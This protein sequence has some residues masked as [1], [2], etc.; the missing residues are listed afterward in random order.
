[1]RVEQSRLQNKLI[2]EA[3]KMRDGIDD[4]DLMTEDLL[5]K[6]SR[7]TANSILPDDSRSREALD[8]IRKTLEVINESSPTNI[9]ECVD[10]VTKRLETWEK[11]E[12]L[13]KDLREKS[14]KEINRLRAEVQDKLND[15]ATAK[16]TNEGQKTQY[17]AQIILLQSTADLNA[18]LVGK[19]TQEAADKE[20]AI[21]NLKNSLAELKNLSDEQKEELEKLQDEVNSNSKE[22][23]NLRRINKEKESQ[24]RDLTSELETFERTNEKSSLGDKEKSEILE[25]LKGENKVLRDEISEKSKIIDEISDNLASQ[26]RTSKKLDMEK[27]AVEEELE[28]LKNE[29]HQLKADLMRTST[30]KSELE[31][32]IKLNEGNSPE[33]VRHLEKILEEKQKE[34][35]ESEANLVVAKRY[36]QLYPDLVVEKQEIDNKLRETIIDLEQA[37]RKVEDLKNESDK[38]KFKLSN[39]ENISKETADIQKEN[40]KLKMRLN[41][42]EQSSGVNKETVD[43]AKKQ[44]ED[45]ASRDAQIK[46]LLDE[47]ERL[48][49][50]LNNQISKYNVALSRSFLVRLCH[51]FKE[52]EGESF[53]KWRIFR[54]EAKP[55]LDFVIPKPAIAIESSA[56]EKPFEKGYVA[57]DLV[58]DQEGNALLDSNPILE[59]Y[60]SLNHANEKPMSYINIFKFLEELMDKKFEADNQDALNLRPL[61]DMPSFVMETLMNTFGIQS[62]ANKFLSQFIPGFHQIVKDGHVYGNFFARVIQLFHPDPAPLSLAA[63]LV[64]ARVDF[65]PLIEK[66]DRL[67][68]DLSKDGKKKQESTG[69]AAYENAG[70]GGLALVGDAI[71][72][73]YSLFK[74]DRESGEKA[75]ELIRP[76]KVSIEDFVAF[77]ICHKMAKLGKTPEMIFTLLDK[78][79]GGTI[80]VDEFISG[81]KE[82]LDLW[83]SD[84]NVTKLLKL[85]DTN[86]NNEITKEAFMGK[87]NMKFLIECN[88][89]PTWVVSKAHYLVALLEVFKFKQRKLM[90]HLHEKCEQ[91]G[92]NFGKEDFI[93]LISEY[94]PNLNPENAE[95]LFL[96]ARN[97]QTKA[98][99]FDGISRIMSRYG[100]G[101]LKSFKIR[102]FTHELT[103]REL[104]AYLEDESIS[105]SVKR[106]STSFVV[107]NTRIER[108]EEE[109]VVIKKKV[110]KKLVKRS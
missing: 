92:N 74:S 75:L 27:K 23:R 85:L 33:E 1:M 15:L 103:R 77:K 38:N 84:A 59:A 88:K 94:D 55:V 5:G 72:L 89:N 20:A 102:E 47:I 10:R 60:K 99:G 81:T 54:N 96:E 68:N 8:S 40:Q 61:T 63:Y 82:D 86:G 2:K 80:D 41:F 57:A 3:G 28:K 69:R 7:E 43:L 58:L 105:T 32:K 36:Q 22:L 110:V 65:N 78:D 71:E 25:K 9:P 46:D 56:D 106:T 48:K 87:I 37:K 104:S 79:Q 49:E 76:E 95:K 18:S 35:E 11:L 6:A 67:N 24:I 52:M 29:K 100:Y 16:A 51:V 31:E 17:E 101:E 14:S 45:I 26:E 4:V 53:R 107:G 44:S 97:K 73:V 66:Y 50:T 109:K 70:T 62:L 42:L 90:A 98:V 12:R 21:S 93:G 34:L 30:E 19:L 39:L 108:D 13:R 83:I 91:K 64:K